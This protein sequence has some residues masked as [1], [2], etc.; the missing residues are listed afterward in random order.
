MPRRDDLI[1]FISG[2]RLIIKRRIDFKI[3][4]MVFLSLFDDKKKDEEE[5]KSKTE[6]NIK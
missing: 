3:K 5:Y 1:V 2:S 4:V 6:A